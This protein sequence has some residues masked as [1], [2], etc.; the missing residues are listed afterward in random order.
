MTNLPVDYYILFHEG[1]TEEAKAQAAYTTSKAGEGGPNGVTLHGSALPRSN[2]I[3]FSGL[4]VLLK[5]ATVF[6]K[7]S[8]AYKAL[9]FEDLQRCL[10][11]SEAVDMLSDP[12]AAAEMTK[13][14]TQYYGGSVG[15]LQYINFD[16]EALARPFFQTGGAIQH[17][18][19]DE[20]Q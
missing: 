12:Y 1:H 16:P 2:L 6:K 9:A 13:L 17:D 11:R 10:D 18:Q 7:N 8:G 3:M 14:L 4:P 20:F 19:L 5:K 15:N